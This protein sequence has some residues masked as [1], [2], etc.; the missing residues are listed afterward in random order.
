MFRRRSRRVLG[1]FL[2]GVQV[3]G[4][5]AAAIPDRRDALAG[6]VGT[7]VY[8][9]RDPAASC[10]PVGRA[11]PAAVD[12]VVLGTDRF[13]ELPGELPRLLLQGGGTQPDE[14][15]RPRQGL[16][17]RDHRDAAQEPQRRARHPH[18]RYAGR[19]LLH[20]DLSARHS[21][22]GLPHL[23]LDA[24]GRARFHGRALRQ[25]ERLRL[26]ARRDHRGA[27]FLRSHEHRL[28]Q[29]L[30]QL[31]AVPRDHELHLPRS[32]RAAR[33]PALPD[34]DPAGAGDGLDGGAG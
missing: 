26:E 23:P 8:E 33:H 9:R 17:G 34:G 4:D 15:G 13:P 24:R 18:P 28:Q 20:G 6:P 30:A 7:K 31:R 16:G 10:G 5:R 1:A 3:R 27:D 22:Q 12:P 29:D 2:S 21:Q 19:G 11:I 25:Q 14:P 32:D